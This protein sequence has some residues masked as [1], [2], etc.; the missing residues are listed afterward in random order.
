MGNSEVNY[1]EKPEGNLQ[2]YP[3]D[4]PKELLREILREL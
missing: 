1:M 3:K 4:N 2:G